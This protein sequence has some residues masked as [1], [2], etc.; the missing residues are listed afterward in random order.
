MKDKEKWLKRY[1][2]CDILYKGL[3]CTLEG[4]DLHTS[5]V[6][7]ERVNCPVSEVQLILKELNDLTDADYSKVFEFLDDM[8]PEDMA[9]F[10]ETH[11]PKSEFLKGFNN[12]DLTY[13]LA[14][15]FRELGYAIGIPKEFYTTI[16]EI[17]NSE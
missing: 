8:F 5:C 9:D 13:G 2:G 7:V 14:D 4:L 11:L 17:R 16:E 1:I 10:N 6:I 3:P 12:R 15:L